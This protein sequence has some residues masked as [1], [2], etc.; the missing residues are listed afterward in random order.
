M[1]MFTANLAAMIMAAKAPDNMAKIM[2][3]IATMTTTLSTAR[4]AST[5]M[6][7]TIMIAIWWM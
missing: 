2:G 5:S 7:R 3:R 1:V 6:E 4:T